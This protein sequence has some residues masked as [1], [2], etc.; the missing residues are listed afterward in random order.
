VGAALAPD[1]SVDELFDAVVD[2]AFVG[3]RKPDPA[4]YALTCE[5]L[6]VPAEQCVLLDDMERNCEAA[7]AFGMESVRFADTTQA[8]ADLGALLAAR[9]AP[10]GVGV[11]RAG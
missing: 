10:P 11:L 2:S 7:R 5:R 8:I 1:A 6:G 4:I 3:L 9:G